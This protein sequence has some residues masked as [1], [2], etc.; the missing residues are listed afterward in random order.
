MRVKLLA[1]VATAF[2]GVMLSSGMASASPLHA[3]AK[4]AA[5]SP[6]VDLRACSG[7]YPS[8]IEFYT[9]DEDYCFGGTV[10]T[11]SVWLGGVFTMHAGSY[12]GAFEYQNA[13]GCFVV[14]FKP[15]QLY[16]IGAGATIT[17]V[18]I[19]PPWN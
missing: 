2:T 15:G 11:M 16:G 9:V 13:N 4:P 5:A 7:S 12:Y 18:T 3:A 17:Q 8:T 1:A 6:S 19:T 14:Y 10:G